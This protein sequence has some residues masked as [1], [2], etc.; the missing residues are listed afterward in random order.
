MSIRILI[1]GAQHGNEKLG[2]RLQRYLKNDKSGKFKNVDYLCGNPRALR[3]D[4]RFIDTDLNRS[5]KPQTPITYEEK[6]AKKILKII[7]Q[8]QYDYVL[9]VHTT[10]ADVGRFF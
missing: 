2:P 1:V 6:R 3:A 5:Y 8:S 4:V 9:D 10:T 7:Q